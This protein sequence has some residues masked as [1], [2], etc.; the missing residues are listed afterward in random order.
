[1]AAPA[2]AAGGAA[3]LPRPL[4]LRKAEVAAAYRECVRVARAHYENFTVG[5]FLLPRALRRHVAA[6]YAFAR[7]ADD[8]ADEGDLAREER[9]ARLD[10]WEWALDEAYR[11][12]PTEPVFV[13]LAD[14]AVRFAI[15]ITPFRRLL[16][17][18][19]GDVDF[20]PFATF[21]DLRAYCRDAADPVGHLILY[22]FGHGDE[23]RQTLSDRV[24]TGLQLANFWQDVLVDA[25]KGRVYVPREDL[26]RFGVSEDD[27][28]H[29]RDDA[30]VRALLAFEVERAR[31]HLVEGLALADTVE[32]R[33]AREVRMFAGGGLA[34]LDRIEADGFATS[35]RRPA[36]SKADKAGVLLRGLLGRGA[37]GAR[38]AGERARRAHAARAQQPAGALHHLDGPRL[39]AAYDFCRDVTQ[40]SS[41]N[42][43]SAFK[44]L[45][46]VQRD[47]LVAVYA[48]CRFVDDVADDARS[49]D[50]QAL[51]DLWRG[52]LANV[53]GGTPTRKIGV[54][55][56]DA[57]AR[58]GLER[59][60]FEDILRGVEM[61]LTAR[62]YLTFEQLEEYC[63]LVASA[64][65]LLCIEIFGYSDPAARGYAVDLGLAFQI[66]N[67]LRDVEEDAQR[68]RIYLPLE[69]LRQFGV[70]E[71]ELLAGR[72][73]PKIAALLA[74]ECGR[75]R[76]FYLRAHGTL[77]PEDRRSLAVAEA[78]CAIY[79]R[80]LHR[81]EARRF[82]VFGRRI[83]LP[84]YEKVGLAAFGW[85]RARLAGLAL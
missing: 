51:L 39:Q 61:D 81:I 29:G 25:R 2:V 28:L 4:S 46:P 3:L 33:L 6:I 1:V 64:V 69:D 13:A 73:S 18:F 68:G 30:P 19:R 56:V 50:P 38:A 72:Y 66:T 42:F 52:E 27:L 84:A 17:A 58:F 32:P 44:L 75:A 48:F 71:E 82:D 31:A 74:F 12:R 55:L 62:R 40:R 83:A 59:R 78:M 63:Y 21:E 36:L 67:I 54:A 9:L 7:A 77:P 80:L 47:A 16:R 34:I 45:G 53:Y 37:L 60:H 79:E 22:L 20:R 49:R 85:V 14:T 35:V 65:G 11:G 15:P 57:V 24:C 43:F 5:S 41:S 23:R 10:A 76:A 70:E 8:M 26:E